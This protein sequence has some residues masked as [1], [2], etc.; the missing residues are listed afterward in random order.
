MLFLKSLSSSLTAGGVE[1]AQIPPGL[2]SALKDKVTG[3]DIFQK[4]A[5]K[6]NWLLPSL[7][8]GVKVTVSL[9]DKGE[10]QKHFRLC[11]NCMTVHPPKPNQKR[12]IRFWTLSKSLL[13]IWCLN[14]LHNLRAF[15]LWN[16]PSPSS[17]GKTHS[18]LLI[19]D[20]EKQNVYQTNI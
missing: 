9:S 8:T 16:H 1:R 15:L 7:S 13:L 4:L 17:G 6:P 14:Q 19:C 18:K 2:L 3:G 11:M 10:V 12:T 5:W 20:T